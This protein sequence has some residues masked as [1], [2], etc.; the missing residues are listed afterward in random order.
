[1]IQTF[2]TGTIMF[3]EEKLSDDGQLV[4]NGRFQFVAADAG[5]DREEIKD[6]FVFRCKGLPAMAIKECGIGGTGVCQ[7]YID[8]KLVQKEGYKDK[9]PTLVIRNWVSTSVM[10][11]DPF[12]I[13]DAEMAARDAA[14]P[15]NAPRPKQ[16]FAF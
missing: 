6:E 15:E 16:A 14:N 2:M 1:M 4:C 12:E 13:A 9:I 8:L 10:S 3:I 5:A 7:G 11:P